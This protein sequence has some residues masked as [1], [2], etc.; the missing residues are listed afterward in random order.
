[1][2]GGVAVLLDNKNRTQEVA[3]SLGSLTADRAP[4]R[5]V[6][7]DHSRRGRRRHLRAQPP[8]RPTPSADDLEHYSSPAPGPRTQRREGRDHIVIGKGR[9]VSF[10]DDGYW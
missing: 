1:V 7:P 9:Y 6:P 10:V 8:Q 4:T 5:R 3:L 2:A